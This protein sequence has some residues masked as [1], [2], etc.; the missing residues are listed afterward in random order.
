MF[1]VDVLLALI[2]KVFNCSK[3]NS[4]VSTTLTGK[5]QLT[6]LCQQ[7]LHLPEFPVKETRVCF[8]T[9]TTILFGSKEQCYNTVVCP[10]CVYA[11][12]SSLYFLMAAVASTESKKKVFNLEQRESHVTEW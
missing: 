4:P 2:A 11:A 7:C 12:Y 3:K 5:A 1:Y 6:E 8:N 9:H 10:N